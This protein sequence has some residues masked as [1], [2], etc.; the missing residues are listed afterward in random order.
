MKVHQDEDNAYNNIEKW[1][2]MNIEVDRLAKDYLWHQIHAGA[3]HQPHEA[4]PGAIQPTT[5]EYHNVPCTIT[6]HLFKTIKDNIQTSELKLLALT[7]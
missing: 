6:S 5:M 7:K 4:I 3:T 1:G 2:Q